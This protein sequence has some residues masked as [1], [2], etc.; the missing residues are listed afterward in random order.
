MIHSE[1]IP[2]HL[3]RSF[4]IQKKKH[5]LLLIVACHILTYKINERSFYFCGMYFIWDLSNEVHRFEACITL[6]DL[7]AWR[8]WSNSSKFC[9]VFE[10]CISFKPS[11]LIAFQALQWRHWHS[12]SWLFFLVTFSYSSVDIEKNLRQLLF[13][14]LDIILMVTANSI[15]AIHKMNQSSEILAIVESPFMVLVKAIL[16]LTVTPWCDDVLVYR[17]TIT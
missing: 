17:V 2:Q 16:R 8:K 14:T 3:P 1:D 9:E 5:L 13:V 4:V 15:L 10:M 11:F 6:T 12:L 7:T